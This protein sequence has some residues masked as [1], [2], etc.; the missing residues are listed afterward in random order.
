[1]Q[2]ICAFHKFLSIFSTNAG[3]LFIVP[4]F[5]PYSI[6]LLYFC[7]RLAVVSSMTH[8][9]RG[10]VL[11]CIRYGDTS[12]IC[13]VYTELLGLQSYIIKGVRSSSARHKKAAL[14]FPMSLLDMT[15]HH[16]PQRNLQFIREFQPDYVYKNL[17]EDVVRNSVA[18][19]AAEVSQQ[20]VTDQD[21]DQRF[22]DF[23][24]YFLITLDEAPAGSL[25]N[26]PLFFMINAARIAGFKL[27]GH[28]SEHTPY[29][30]LTEGRFSEKQAALPPF[31]AGEEAIL[32]DALNKESNL[33]QV[34]KIKIKAAVRSNL[35]Q[36]YVS[37]L[38]WHVPHF[39]PLKSVAVLK[40]IL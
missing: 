35:L 39:A 2:D 27:S 26:Y 28:Y 37:F 4:I 18:V 31:I 32:M 11:R 25:G 40:A 1:M 38:Q 14:L 21:P 24:H 6:C 8:N 5:Y 12:L 16:H 3:L 15:V 29:V 10:I 23:L 33:E 7:K 30:D 34:H 9:T 19:F 36:Y 22:Y 20:L 13:S 17:H